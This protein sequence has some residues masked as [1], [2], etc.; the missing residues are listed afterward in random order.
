MTSSTDPLGLRQ[1]D[2]IEKWRAEVE[3]EAQERAAER[4]REEHEQRAATMAREAAARQQLEARVAELEEQTRQ[5][6]VDLN[7]LA[8]ATREAID[9]LADVCEKLDQRDEVSKLKEAIS[10]KLR[11]RE[12]ELKEERR[13]RFAR[14]K[15]GEVTNLPDFLPRRVN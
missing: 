11:E 1:H 12:E 5:L 15:D 3:R 13:F 8:R 10:R 9:T 2:P 4:Q 6:T 7:D 14:E